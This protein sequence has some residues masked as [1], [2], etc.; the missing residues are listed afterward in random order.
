M[1]ATLPLHA[2]QSNAGTIHK[3]YRR[4]LYIVR[5]L[6]CGV[7]SAHGVP[8]TCDGRGAY[9]FITNLVAGTF[10]MQLVS[11]RFNRLKNDLAM[12]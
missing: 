9:G 11:A 6:R 12:A 8:L 4:N 7:R 1:I 10:R 5:S 3:M 2:A